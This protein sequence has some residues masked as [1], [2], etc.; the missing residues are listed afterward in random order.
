VDVREGDGMKGVHCSWV[1][2]LQI[3]QA[4][5]AGERGTQ[6]QLEHMRCVDQTTV[7]TWKAVCDLLGAV[8]GK[9]D[10]S[11]VSHFQPTH[12]REIARAFRKRERNPAKWTEELKEEMADWVDRCEAEEWTVPEL[13]K[14]LQQSSHEPAE[15]GCTVEDLQALVYAGKRFGAVYADPPW[16]Y[17]NQATR[18]STDNHYDPLTLD[19]IAALP[20]SD[21][22]ADEAH[23]HL[24]TTNAFLFECPRLMEAWGFTYKGVFVWVKPQIGLG[25]YWRVAHEFLLLGVRGDKTFADQS[26]PSWGSFDRLEHSAK[27]PEVRG[28][29]E[30][31]SPAPWLELFSR[32]NGP[33]PEGWTLWGNEVPREQFQRNAEAG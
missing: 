19:D 6:S 27:P 5:V 8:E 13:K 32:W 23:L 33:P 24:W 2:M 16:P 17:E 14:R 10:L 18:A 11:H 31:A 3:R 4:L 25:N 9:H 29:V 15:P 26:M 22:V 28:M 12:A 21:L 30:R 7:S 1:D 20:V